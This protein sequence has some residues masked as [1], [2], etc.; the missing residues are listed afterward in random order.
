MLQEKD[1]QSQDAKELYRTYFWFMREIMPAKEALVEK[2][3]DIA[4]IVESQPAVS[5]PE[6]KEDLTQI[7]LKPDLF[8][9]PK[10]E[11]Q[12][13]SSLNKIEESL[14]KR[15][16]LPSSGEL[17]SNIKVSKPY[18]RGDDVF[19]ELL[20]YYKAN[21]LEK[22]DA[23]P[24]LEEEANCLLAT[25]AA[26][27][28]LSLLIE[29]ESRSGKSLIIDKLSRIL[30]SVIPVDVCSNKALFDMTDS[31]NTSDFIYIREYQ[32]AI[33][34]NPAVKEVIKRI[35]E[36]KDATSD[37]L[38]ETKTISGKVTVLSTGAD[39]NKQTQKRD[40]EVSGRFIILRTRSDENKINKICQ[41]QDGLADGTI[42]DINFSNSK[43]EKLKSHVR[44][45]L[46]DKTMGFENPFAKNF[47]ESYMPKTKKSIY[48]RTLYHSMMNAFTKFDRP[49]RI[50]KD[51]GKTITNIADI[52]LVYSLYHE[53]YCNTLKRLSAQ[54]FE[55]ME[56]SLSEA[57]R[58]EKR[59]EH[60]DEVMKIDLIMQKQINWRELWNS[61]YE[62]MKQNN[63]EY[64]EEWVRLQ[65]KDGQ[66]VVYDPIIKRDVFL[67]DFNNL[68]FVEGGKIDTA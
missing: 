61:A 33:E 34:G 68:A 43:Y 30:T 7:E 27:S 14:E 11:I 29:G 17:K 3:A 47:G 49:N 64:V 52:Y 67:C 31:V 55:A 44:D 58:E 53:T 36:K 23:I 9:E 42:K 22:E 50:I 15:A 57:E 28:R 41:Y 24:V 63:P 56:K 46:E 13:E 18:T 45:T 20:T 25:V 59:K 26:S 60:E 62:H 19:T 5:E 12:P 16:E 65:S 4:V 51:N 40:V 37:S 2:P 8:S 1:L 38:G 54:S 66:V 10:Q 6:K 35:T 39:E 32:S 48:Y 21:K